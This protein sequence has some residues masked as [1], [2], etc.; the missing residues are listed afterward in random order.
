MHDKMQNFDC[1]L[2][3]DLIML[4]LSKAFDTMPHRKLLSKHKKYGINGNINKWIQ[5]FLM[6]RKQHVIV[7]REFSKPCSIDCG[8]RQGTVL[9]LLL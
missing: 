1:M 6:H 4:D 3:T 8:V 2:Q 5:S 7:E 9:G